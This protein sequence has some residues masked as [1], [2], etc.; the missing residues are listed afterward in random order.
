[1]VELEF[2]FDQDIGPL[3]GMKKS[4]LHK[5]FRLSKSLSYVWKN[6]ATCGDNC[7]KRLNACRWLGSWTWILIWPRYAYITFKNALIST[8]IRNYKNERHF[9][10]TTSFKIYAHDLWQPKRRFLHSKSCRQGKVPCH[11]CKF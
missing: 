1:M 9:P 5:T 7:V 3:I 4:D 6:L 2:S 10:S 11:F 8:K